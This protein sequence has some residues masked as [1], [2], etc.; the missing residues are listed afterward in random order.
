MADLAEILRREA[1]RHVPDGDA[2]FDR[3]DR[4]RFAPEPV[5]AP[6]PFLRRFAGLRPVAA[7]A[8]VVATL[9]AGFTG[10]KLLTAE[11]PDRAPAATT[12]TTTASPASSPSPSPAVPGTSS[13]AA[14]AK[15][16]AGR[17]QVTSAPPSFQPVNGFLTSRGVIDVYSTDDW[18]QSDVTVA[19]T[20]VITAL[21]LAISVAR[22]DGV[23]STGSWSTIPAAMITMS[24][25][26]EK[27]AVIY[28]FIL[29]PGG[30]LAA[31]SYVFAAQY[32]H[33]AGKRQ[34]GAD[35]YG[36]IVAAGDRKAEVTG[37][38]P[39]GG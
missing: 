19:S 23:I 34:P 18:A 6:R 32:Q 20:K 35:L 22:T 9:V 26:E 7:A 29:K 10:I 3:I 39:A 38:F 24:V 28:R 36:G 2:M 25:T 13:P 14:K 8:S 33:A 5:R 17:G 12:T 4:G 30:T 11:E 1:D 16:P 37:G 27:A 15:S 31:G 21:D